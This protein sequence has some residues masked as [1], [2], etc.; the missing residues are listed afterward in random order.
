M[1][2]PY[3]YDK[4]DKHT[5][6]LVFTDGDNN[7]PR[8][9]GLL[10]DIPGRIRKDVIFVLINSKSNIMRFMHDIMA[11]GIPLKNIIGINTEEFRK[12]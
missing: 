1:K 9:W 5:T 11:N 7:D 8:G 12:R 4:K 6:I 10:K 2:K 3:Y